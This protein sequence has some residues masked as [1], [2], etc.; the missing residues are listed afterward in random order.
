MA[1]IGN[2]GNKGGRIFV[3]FGDERDFSAIVL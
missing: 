2:S 1:V 3:L